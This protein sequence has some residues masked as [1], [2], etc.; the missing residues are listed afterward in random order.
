MRT[1]AVMETRVVGTS[2]E[3]SRA[4]ARTTSP[5]FEARRAEMKSRLRTLAPHTASRES[6]LAYQTDMTVEDVR[7]L[8]GVES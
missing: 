3:A 6:Y 4:A 5:E 2:T 1:L 8:G 7:R